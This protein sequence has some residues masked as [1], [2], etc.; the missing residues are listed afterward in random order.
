MLAALSENEANC[1]GRFLSLMLEVVQRWHSEKTIFEKVV[2]K[3]VS[4][5]F[6][7]TRNFLG[8]AVFS[9]FFFHKLYGRI[10]SFVFP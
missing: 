5:R 9:G 2:T 8:V 10:T 3:I 1:F 7:L 6:P 4:F